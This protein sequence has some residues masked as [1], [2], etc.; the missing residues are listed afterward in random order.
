MPKISVIV[1]VFNVA[2]FLGACL[3]S[4]IGQSLS[5]WELICID[6]GSTDDSK[7]ILKEYEANDDRICVRTQRNS[8]QGAA[9]NRGLE[10][11][12]GDYVVFLDSD[13]ILL[14]TAL[15]ELMVICE[16]DDL[17]HLVY[18]GECFF[19]GLGGDQERKRMLDSQYRPPAGLV[20]KVMSGRELFCQLVHRNQF[21]VSPCLRIMRRS[22]LVE[23]ALFFPEQII[24]ED[25]AFTPFAL[26]AAH[27]AA[28]IDTVFYRRR[29]TA[30]STTTNPDWA[31]RRAADGLASYSLF[32]RKVLDRQDTLQVRQALGRFS[33]GFL[34]ACFHQFS[35][36]G[37]EDRQ[38]A[39]HRLTMFL[40]PEAHVLVEIVVQPALMAF[41]GQMEADRLSRSSFP[42][43]L[44]RKFARIVKGCL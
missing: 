44:V 4:V 20:G 27:R 38:R 19:D 40:D 14:P 15:E 18:A 26:L 33:K 9:R 23:G 5:E 39:L 31:I 2:P 28:V 21:T 35:I 22:V 42:R 41:I 37:K 36:L 6:D 8:G 29:L 24:L 30:V 10:R 11:A 16:R 32:L 1:P 43:R 17:D 3:D 7:L 12:K 25:N 13:D 34:E